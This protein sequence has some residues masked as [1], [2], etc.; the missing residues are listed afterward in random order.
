[1][2]RAF[3]ALGSNLA[4]P[5]K[6]VREALAA[7]VQLDNVC[8]VRHS[9][10][11]RTVPFGYTDQPDFINAVAELDTGLSPLLL[12]DALL[13]LEACFG[14]IRTFRYAPRL[15]DLD[16]LWYQGVTRTHGRLILPH[17]CMTEREF[18]I[19]PL[20]EIAPEL[21]LGPLGTVIQLAGQFSGEGITRLSE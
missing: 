12:L 14:R 8:L 16:L 1:M 19:V 6:Q 15:L 10:L 3:V 9:S 17:P 4:D 5:I 7:L 20:A 13:S 11:Y 18:V 21:D 2:T